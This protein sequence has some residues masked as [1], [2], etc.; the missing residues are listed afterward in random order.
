MSDMEQSRVCTRCNATKPLYEFHKASR[1]RLGVMA[2]CKACRSKYAA[3]QYK[4]DKAKFTAFSKNYAIKNRA[5]LSAYQKEWA[6]AN[7]DKVLAAQKRYR[8]K[9]KELLANKRKTEERKAY[10][11]NYWQIRKA[12]KANNGVFKIA[13]KEI[14]ALYSKPCFYC[15]STNSIEIDHIIPI[16]RGGT[17]GIGNL[18]SSCSAC[19]RSKSN[20]TI[21]EWKKWKKQIESKTI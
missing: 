3:D 18:A 7:P 14:I 4:K 20:K 16:D 8:D 21:T 12:K 15:G 19:N 11:R 5:T 17:H 1:E 9:N 6:K 13:K 10:S 2:Q